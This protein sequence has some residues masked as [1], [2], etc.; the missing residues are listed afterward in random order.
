[1]YSRKSGMVMVSYWLAPQ[2]SYA[3]VISPKEI[4]PFRLPPAAE[5]SSLI[6]QYQGFIEKSVRDPM[7][8]DNLAGRR[9]YDALDAP[10]ASLIPRGSQVVLMPD[11]P[12]HRLNFETLPVYGENRRYWIDDV[13]VSIAPSLSILVMSPPAKVEAPRSLLLFGDASYT[14]AA[15][16]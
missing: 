2:Q 15:Y 9:L 12:L 11:G 14:G 1:A 3:W 6:E 13:T 8:S 10:L 16:Q 5:I 7:E 4:R